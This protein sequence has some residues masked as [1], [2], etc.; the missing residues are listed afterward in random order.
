M[1]IH[2]VI[3]PA[4]IL[5]LSLGCAKNPDTEV[6]SAET[7]ITSK[8]SAARND[9][10]LLEQKHAE[11]RAKNPGADR[12]ERAEM[13]RKQTSE[14]AEQRA[15]SQTSISG[16]QKDLVNAQ[17]N[18][19]QDRR[20]FES[21]AKERMTKIEAKAKE[22]KTKSARLDAKKKGEFNQH[23]ATFNT[24]RSAT[25]AKVS[26]LPAVTNEGWATAKKDVDASFDHMENTLDKLGKDL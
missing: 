23:M 21:K 22:L 13:N 20:D 16:A 18:L 3:L 24:E 4:A 7:E 12:D 19:A 11:E 26:Q 15:D 9:Q 14:H 8:E 17:E 5:T 25:S 2:H 1:N 10:A 6:R